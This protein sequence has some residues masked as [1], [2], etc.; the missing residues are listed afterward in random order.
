VSLN[1]WFQTDVAANGVASGSPVAVWR[2]TAVGRRRAGF[3]AERRRRVFRSDAE[4]PLDPCPGRRGAKQVPAVAPRWQRR[5]G[6]SLL[7]DAIGAVS[8]A[9][10]RRVSA[11]TRIVGSLGIG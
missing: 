1:A 10:R 3:G 7:A 9:E 8:V 4:C 6:A 2:L 11:V 5:A